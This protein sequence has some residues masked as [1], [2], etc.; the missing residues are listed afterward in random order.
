MSNFSMD[1][2]GKIKHLTYSSRLADT[3]DWYLSDISNGLKPFIKQ[4]RKAV[5]FEELG[6]GT[7]GHFMAKKMYFGVDYRVG[8][9]YGLW[10]KIIKVV[11]A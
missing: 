6:K 3:N 9:G 7:T 11:N 8:F 10:Q 4:L 2:K 5:E 1:P